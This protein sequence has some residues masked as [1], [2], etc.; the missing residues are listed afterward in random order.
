VAAEEHRPLRACKGVETWSGE[1]PEGAGAALGT[2]RKG[3]GQHTQERWGWI[4]MGE[5]EGQ[6]DTWGLL[7]WKIEF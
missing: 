5:R 4:R 6:A 7:R 3:C 1:M 2:G